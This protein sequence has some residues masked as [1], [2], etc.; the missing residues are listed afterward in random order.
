MNLRDVRKL[1]DD[2]EIEFVHGFL[3]LTVGKKY[4]VKI[5]TIGAYI[6]D[7]N[8]VGR[9]VSSVIHLENHFLSK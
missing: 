6:V 2:D 9:P 7:D 1:K 8:G 3:P 5:T 4:K